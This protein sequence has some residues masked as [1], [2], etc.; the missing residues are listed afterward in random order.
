MC[1][2]C[3]YFKIQDS[4]VILK[5]FNLK[6][7]FTKKTNN[8]FLNLI[9]RIFPSLLY[10]DSNL[11]NLFDCF[12]DSLSIARNS[13]LI[14]LIKTLVLQRLTQI[15]IIFTAKNRWLQKKKKK[16]F[17]LNRNTRKA[18]WKNVRQKNR[19]RIEPHSIASINIFY[20]LIRG[21]ACRDLLNGRGCY[22]LGFL[23]SDVMTSDFED[24]SKVRVRYF[25][26][27]TSCEVFDRKT[28][29]NSRGWWKCSK[30]Q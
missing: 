14:H 13:V 23:Q 18:H 4:V 19:T 7:R 15:F 5:K 24:A 6:S 17:S 30:I 2:Y 10:C 27:F 20:I 11:W 16:Y 1:V 9:I 25:V 3:K 29:R 12:M 21:T 8:G 22:T 28:R 26:D